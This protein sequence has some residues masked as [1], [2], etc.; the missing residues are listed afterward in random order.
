MSKVKQQIAALRRENCKLKAE[1]ERLRGPIPQSII[2]GAGKTVEDWITENAIK[3]GE[4]IPATYKGAAQVLVMTIA[5]EA[6]SAIRDVAR[7]TELVAENRN[8]RQENKDL[9]FL[10]PQPEKPAEDQYNPKI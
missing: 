9:R 5:P 7:I 2:W 10:L 3:E 1:I 4:A 8:L 6:M